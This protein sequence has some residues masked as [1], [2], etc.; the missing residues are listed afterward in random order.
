MSDAQYT[1]STQ[2]MKDKLKALTANQ[3]SFWKPPEG[4]TVIRILPHLP[5]Q[6]NFWV[7]NRVHYI[8][9]KPYQC[10]GDPCVAC[11]LS[12]KLI[13]S[14]DSTRQAKGSKMAVQTQTTANIAVNHGT[15]QSENFVWTLP[16]SVMQDL[17]SAYFGDYA[18]L[19]HPVTGYDLTLTRT[20]QGK[21]T[22]YKIMPRK[23]SSRT[24]KQMMEG[25][26][27]LLKLSKPATD[28]EIREAVSSYLKNSGPVT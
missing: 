1:S 24:T 21:A 15:P 2:A 16:S 6:E 12:G 25:R 27:D 5:G 22:R 28:A 8:A 4:P 19:D 18:G 14:D 7:D 11:S 26:K 20:G 17:I 13:D 3:F 9:N 23:N 10:Q